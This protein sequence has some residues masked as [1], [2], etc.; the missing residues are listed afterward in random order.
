MKYRRKPMTVEV[1]KWTGEN[2]SEVKNFV[3]DSLL[4]Y[5]DNIYIKSFT[6]SFFIVFIGQY[7]IKHTDGSFDSTN[8]DIFEQCYEL[9]EEV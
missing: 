4:I 9:C 5:E 1:I 7:I 8:Q 6:L 3:G 2:L